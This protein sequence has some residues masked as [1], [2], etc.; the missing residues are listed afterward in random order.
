MKRIF[1][2]LMCVVTIVA[3]GA[4]A[5]CTDDNDRKEDNVPD[6]TPVAYMD[7]GLP[8]GTL[9]KT[10]NE[11]GFYDYHEA[12]AAYGDSMP[13][14]AQ[15]D[16]LTDECDWRWDASKKGYYITG[17][18]GNAIFMPAAGYI[19]CVDD[20]RRV[21]ELGFYW[22]RSTAFEIEEGYAWDLWFTVSE[23]DVK[24]SGF[25]HNLS[26]RCVKNQQQ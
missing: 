18:N 8:S 21:G 9:W 16:E 2:A 3:L 19:D 26:V 24:N 11:K 6:A 1:F 12:M 22:S 20:V 14:K 4:M 5:A 7:L 25:C 10:V 15:F 17:P 13:T 23:I